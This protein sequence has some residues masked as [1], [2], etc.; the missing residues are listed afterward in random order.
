MTSRFFLLP[1]MLAIILIP[2]SAQTTSLEAL[3]AARSFR[4][5]LALSVSQNLQTSGQALAML[6]SN[7]GASGRAAAADDDFAYAALDVGYRLLALERPAAAEEF[8]LAAE[9]GLT[10]VANRSTQLRERAEHLRQLALIRGRFLSRVAQAKADIEEA[11]RLQPDDS[12]F[13]ES[14]ALI[15]R[16]RGESFKQTGRN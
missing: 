2:A 1:V 6:R 5:E 8:F 11:I 10:V 12:S 4:Q 14:R 13:R 15:A 9:Q 3:Q 16:G 7:K